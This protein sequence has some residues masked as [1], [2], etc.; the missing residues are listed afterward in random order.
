MNLSSSNARC[1]NFSIS[2]RL[3]LTAKVFR[4]ST[5]Q[6]YASVYG[7]TFLKRIEQTRK[8]TIHDDYRKMFNRYVLPVFHD[9]DLQQITKEKVKAFA[10]SCLQ[11][12]LSP[13]TVQTL[14]ACSAASSVMQ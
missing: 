11:Y 12:G 2:S 1:C 7:E 9:Q 5:Y 6:H 8:H 4:P 13:K 10:V 14:S 3:K